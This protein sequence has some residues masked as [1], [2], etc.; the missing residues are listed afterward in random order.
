MNNKLQITD[1]VDNI[2]IPEFVGQIPIRSEITILGADEVKTST[3]GWVCQEYSGGEVYGFDV[4]DCLVE[5]PLTQKSDMCPGR[6]ISVPTLFGYVV[7]EVVDQ[8][9]KLVAMTTTK[10]TLANLEFSRDDRLCW[11]SSYAVNLK[12]IKKHSLSTIENK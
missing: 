7:M 5:T 3:L 9:G 2:E 10:G 8:D 4:N 12:G 11:T 1:S 6:K